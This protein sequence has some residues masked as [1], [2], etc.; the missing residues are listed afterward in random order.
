MLCLTMLA[1]T[2]KIINKNLKM[3]KIQLYYYSKIHQMRDY[4][5]IIL[6][7]NLR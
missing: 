4:Q 6:T 3:S 7:N 2:Q 1:S 5:L